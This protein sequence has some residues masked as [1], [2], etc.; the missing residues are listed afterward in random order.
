MSNKIHYI[1]EIRT[2]FE[3]KYKYQRG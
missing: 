3:N 1:F 2:D